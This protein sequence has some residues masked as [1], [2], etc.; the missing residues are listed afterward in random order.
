MTDPELSQDY[1]CDVFLGDKVKLL[2]PK[3]GLRAGT[4]AVLLAASI[5]ARTGQKLLEAGLGSGVVSL[6]VAARLGAMHITGVEVQK[7]LVCLA[8]KNAELNQVSDTFSIIQGDVT[9]SGTSWQ[10]MGLR[11]DNYDH[12]Y[13]NPPFY[14]HAKKRN[15]TD[16]VKAKAHIHNTDDLVHWVRFLVAH[17][18]QKGSITLIHLPEFLPDL[19]RHLE[20]ATGDIRIYPIFSKRYEP[21]SRIIVQS[22]K[23]SR[24]PLHIEPGIVMHDETGAF[25]K[26]AVSILKYGAAL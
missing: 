14:D 26:K 16:T 10:N 5:K 23:G 6:C 21:A 12:T 13:A 1:T 18:K 15:P 2:Q 9:G 25:C 19:L 17:T 7:E 22:V 24:G 3:K 8:R 11:Q 20:K 4:D